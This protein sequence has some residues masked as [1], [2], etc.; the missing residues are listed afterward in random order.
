MQPDT[1]DPTVPALCPF[2]PAGEVRSRVERDVHARYRRQQSAPSNLPDALAEDDV[3]DVLDDE[4]AWPDD[5][6]QRP[7]EGAGIVFAVIFG[8]P[9]AIFIAA[10]V[11]ALW[12]LMHR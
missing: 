2:Q 4:I 6:E 9:L 3:G 11:N 5:P 7:P 8:V 10:L 12:N 1:T